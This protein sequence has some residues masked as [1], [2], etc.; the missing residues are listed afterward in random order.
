MILPHDDDTA[1][2]A[3]KLL[4]GL[5]R[6]G[7]AAEISL[8]G[9]RDRRIDRARKSG[10][11]TMLFVNREPGP[12]D[13]LHVSLMPLNMTSGEED[14]ALRLREDLTKIEQPAPRFEILPGL[15][16]KDLVLA[17]WS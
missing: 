6:A 8:S 1:Q 4:Y 11:R 3:M 15:Q 17:P 16:P 12:P 10:V 9:K 2:D 14:P 5:R 13:R 7:I